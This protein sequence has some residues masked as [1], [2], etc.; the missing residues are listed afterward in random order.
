[1]AGR[2]SGFQ[3]WVLVTFQGRKCDVSFRES[4]GYIHL[5]LTLWPFFIPYLK[6]HFL[7]LKG[8]RELIIPKER[9][10]KCSIARFFRH[11]STCLKYQQAHGSNQPLEAVDSESTNYSTED[12]WRLLQVLKAAAKHVTKFL[13]SRFWVCVCVKFCFFFPR[14]K[15]AQNS[16][17]R[18]THTN[19]AKLIYHNSQVITN[20]QKKTKTHTTPS[21]RSSKS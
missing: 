3:N 1:M 7:A 11:F 5:C 13:H 15:E 4:I 19:P 12:G 9:S 16:K 8:S 20:K 17:E 10:R 6:G 2:W 14:K 21:I 18:E